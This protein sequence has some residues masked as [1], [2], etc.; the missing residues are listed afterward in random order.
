LSLY[1][2]G[3]L[4][5]E[6]PRRGKQT[7]TMFVRFFG[8]LLAGDG[9]E[10]GEVDLMAEFRFVAIFVDGEEVRS[11]DDVDRLPCL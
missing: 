2:G 8:I 5:V 7:E 1:I 4:N 10:F 6:I 3:D 11:Q 9:S